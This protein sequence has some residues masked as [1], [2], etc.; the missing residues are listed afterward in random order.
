MYSYPTDDDNV[1]K[2]EKG[3]KK[4][5]I[6]R[7]IKFQDCKECLEKNKTMLKSQYRFRSEAHSAFTEKVNKVALSANDD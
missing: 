3:T 5:V 2:K 7:E 1:D 6:K 4:C